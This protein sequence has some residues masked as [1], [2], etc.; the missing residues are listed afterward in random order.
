MDTADVLRSQLR[1]VKASERIL[2]ESY[3]NGNDE[4]ALK[5]VTRLTQAVQTYL[6]ALEAADLE[7]RIEALEAQNDR[8]EQALTQRSNR[9]GKHES[10][11]R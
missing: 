1:A 6:K 4:R 5:A 7:D 10:T 11:H 8:I 3:E 9:H 2:Y